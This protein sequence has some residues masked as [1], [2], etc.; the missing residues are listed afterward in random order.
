ML[1]LKETVSKK[2]YQLFGKDC[3]IYS[4]P[5]KVNIIGEHTDYNQGLVLPFTID[6]SMIL[7]IQPINKNSITIHSLNY[8]ETIQ[9]SL[10]SDINKLPLWGKYIYGLIQEIYNKTH[11]NFGFN[12][13]VGSDIP[14]QAGLSSSAALETV[15]AFAI[16]DIFQLELS[17]VQLARIGQLAENNHIG[18]RSGLMD[19]FSCLIGKKDYFFSLDCKNMSYEYHPLDLDEYTFAVINPNY[20]DPKASIRYNK[21]KKQCEDAVFY[22]QKTFPEVSSLREVK[23]EYLQE[24][25]D[26]MDNTLFQRTKFILEENQRVEKATKAIVNKDFQKLGHL[27]NDSHLGI[28]NLFNASTTLVDNIFEINTNISYVLGSRIIGGGFGGCILSLLKN[29]DLEEYKKKILKE[30]YSV[31]N[32]K[33]EI[34]KIASSGCTSKLT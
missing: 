22:I 33:L 13:V 18:I 8:N 3:S 9:L 4:S 16:N 31:S 19:Q 20:K 17:S 23:I 11:L 29:K 24:L 1:D 34:A 28:E 26:Y 15:V 5:A 14:I 6:K 7:A 10:D 12:A 30:F 32:N 2:F 21:R 27:L 25:Q